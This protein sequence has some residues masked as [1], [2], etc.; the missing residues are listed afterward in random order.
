MVQKHH[1][2]VG[3]LRSHILNSWFQPLSST[4]ALGSVFIP[5]TGYIKTLFLHLYIFYSF[6]FLKPSNE[7]LSTC[8]VLIAWTP[9][10]FLVFSKWSF[11]ITSFSDSIC[12]GNVKCD[13]QNPCTPISEKYSSY[14]IQRRTSTQ[15]YHKNNH[16]QIW[17]L[18]DL[19]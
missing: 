7:S 8:K 12:Y 19:Q 4:I 5:L 2:T 18:S 13:H 3:I 14:F 17:S 1:C 10:C 16:A 9:R 11:M 6:S 15:S